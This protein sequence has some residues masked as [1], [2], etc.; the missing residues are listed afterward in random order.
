ME[1]WESYKEGNAGMME[2]EAANYELQLSYA[3]LA[4]S[5]EP[6][7]TK[8][9]TTLMQVLVD[10]QGQILAIVDA[11]GQ[12]LA[13]GADVIGFLSELNPVMVLATGGLAMV[14]LKATGTAVG[15]AYCRHGNCSSNKSLSCCRSYSFCP[16]VLNS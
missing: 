7:E 11:T 2:A 9:K 3:E 14:A 4:K 1:L 6:I 10:H 5:I 16:Q 15:N 8:I 13:V 12:I